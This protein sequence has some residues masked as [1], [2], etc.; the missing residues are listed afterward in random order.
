MRKK[1]LYALAFVACL[2]LAGVSALACAGPIGPDG[3]QG[4]AGPQGTTGLQ[5]TAGSTYACAD[6]HDEGEELKARQI[7]YAASTHATG[8]HL[9]DS[10]SCGIC[11][12]SQGFQE[13]LAAGTYDNLEESVENP[14]PINCRTCHEIHETY[15]GDDWGLRVQDAIVLN[16]TQTAY[17]AGK[18]NLCAS[19]HQ[20][21]WSYEIPDATDPTGAYEITSTHLGPHHGP[22]SNVL[23]GEGGYGAY[24]GSDVHYTAVEDACVTCHMS[25]TYRAVAGGHTWNMGYESNG[26]PRT[27]ND[28][29]ETCHTGE[30]DI[31]DFDRVS[32]TDN[33]QTAITALLA[34]LKADLIAN[35]V[36][37][38]DGDAV[39][40]TY[41]N[42]EVGALWNYYIVVEDQ[43]LGVHNPN[44]A[45]FLLETGI[46]ALP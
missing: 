16:L 38:A 36:M 35:G 1:G 12:S 42:A 8:G 22:Q 37:D 5:G 7:Q 46:A 17:D 4:P 18:S 34:T 19:C 39:K 21:R 14:V 24:T 32:A 41:T 45:K 9:Y 25:D 6:C 10:T 20:A 44:Y 23:T 15:T 43:S 27:N 40:G 13:R 2:L 30:G 26:S 11:H 31:D 28:I 3:E 29:C 33:N